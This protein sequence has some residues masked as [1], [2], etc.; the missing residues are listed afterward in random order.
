M[1]ACYAGTFHAPFQYDDGAQIVANPCGGDLSCYLSGR[2]NPPTRY[3][4]YL[5]IGLN[6]WMGGLDVVGFHVFNVAVHLLASILVLALVATTLRAADTA[7]RLGD[8]EVALAS[9]LSA[10]FFAA[11]PVQTQAVTYLVQRFTSMAALF[12]VATLLLHA[13]S[14]LRP[15]LDGLAVLQEAG[16]VAC[17]VAAMFT[18]EIAFTLPVAVVAYDLAFLPRGGLRRLA[19]LAL[20]VALLP[21]VP[22]TRLG[23]PVPISE[24]AAAAAEATQVQTRLGRWDYFA[25]EWRAIAGYLRLLA[26]PTGQSID[27]EFPISFWPWS[28]ATWAAGILLAA[29]LLLGFAL[30]ARRRPPELRVA[31]YGIVLFFLALGVESTFIPIIDVFVEHRIYLPSVGA[32]MAVGGG[33]TPPLAPV[34]AGAAASAAPRGRGMDRPPRRGHGGPEHGLA[35]SDRPLVRRGGEGTRAAARTFQP[36]QRPPRCRRPGGRAPR[37]DGRGRSRPV[38]QRS[39]GPAREPGG[40]RRG[41]RQGRAALAAGHR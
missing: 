36:G 8:R 13:R 23:G 14:R 32:A 1:V 21:I 40:A 30:L 18:K 5:S 15:R 17:A 28:A 24:V 16:A 2:F 25:T 10:L 3:L 4:G 34:V 33:A 37:L 22:L 39:L 26:F 20:L 7:R 6:R 35:R 11:H 38:A 29:L 41:R 12:Y 9:L 19:P 27:H 31:G